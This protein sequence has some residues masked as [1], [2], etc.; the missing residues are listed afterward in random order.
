[1]GQPKRSASKPRDPFGPSM[2]IVCRLAAIMRDRGMTAKQLS[3]MTGVSR[4]TIARLCNN[5]FTR[6]RVDVLSRICAALGIT[7]LDELFE[8]YQADVFFPIRLHKE[9]T[10]HVGSDS[11]AGRA[12]GELEGGHARMSMGAW[13]FRAMKEVHEFLNH[14]VPGIRVHVEEHVRYDPAVSGK[15]TATLDEGNHIIFGSPLA[16]EFAEELVCHTHRVPPYSPDRRGEFPYV[17]NWDR[18]VRSSFG[19]RVAGQKFGIASTRT[20]KLLACH[21]RVASGQGEDAALI[22]TCRIWRSPV[23]RQYGR[24]DENIV[25]A[26]LGYSGIGTYGGAKAL[27]DPASSR[28]LYPPRTGSAVVRPGPPLM[29]VVS[30]AYTRAPGPSP[31]DNRHVRST[32]LVAEDDIR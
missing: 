27:T 1:M 8:V 7:S 26:I 30:V 9:V 32:Q 16:N 28:E 14:T 12:D 24:H 11:L 2:R 19:V 23:R 20:G 17:F 25:I 6:V 13:D 29:R 4:E 21:T 3:R 15:V 10:F 31:H 22:M 18:A 5:T